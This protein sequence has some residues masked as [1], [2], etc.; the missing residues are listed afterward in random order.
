MPRDYWG[1]W[2]RQLDTRVREGD[3]L[4]V[5]ANNAP[6]LVLDHV[7]KGRVAQFLSDQFWLWSRTP[8]G[9]QAELLRRT[10]HWL[11]QEPDL[12]ETALRATSKNTEDGWQLNLTKQSLKDTSAT[13]GVTS[14]DGQ[15]STATLIETSSPGQLTAS[16]P[17]V[18]PGLYRLKDGDKEILAMVAPTQS[19]EFSN[20]ISTSDKVAGIATTTHWLENPLPEIH[21]AS[22]MT[23]AGA[24]AINLKQ[25]HQY[26]VTGSKAY[27]LFPAGLLFI[28]ALGLIMWAWKREG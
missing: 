16:I 11:V 5:G 24:N 20:M 25:N 21:R 9:P 6:L 23:T 3:I 19:P 4:M 8:G 18:N 22:T 12:D 1:P 10:A 17:V 13:I 26:K 28:V 14:P 27:P 2:Y 7:G 15:V